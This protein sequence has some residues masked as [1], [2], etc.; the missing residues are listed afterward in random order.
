MKYLT[1]KDVINNDFMSEIKFLKDL[2]KDYVNVAGGKGAS[3]GELYNANFPIPCGFVILS[4]FFKNFITDNNIN[5]EIKKILKSVNP[6]KLETSK[7]ASKKIQKIIINSKLNKDLEKKILN[8][9]KKLDSKFV[10]VRSSATLEDS[11]SDAWA[12]LLDSFLNIKEQDLLKNIKKCFASLFTQRAIIYRIKRGLLEKEISIAVVVQK[13]INSEKSG[14]AFSINP[15]T[16]D[17]SQIIIEAGYGL[18]EA[19]V[20]G[21]I[22]PDTYIVSKN[23]QILDKQKGTQKKA[24]YCVSKGSGNIWKELSSEQRNKQILSDKKIKELSK[25]IKSIEIHYGF[26]VDVEWAIENNKIYILQSRPITNL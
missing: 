6:E 16:N 9:F 2:T 19:I 3:L 24:L 11:P 10:A 21:G 4:N 8:S 7:A 18:G 15:V 23:Y 13:M 26:P 1:K 14:I 5:L 20:L 17:C 12:G 22:I 25:I